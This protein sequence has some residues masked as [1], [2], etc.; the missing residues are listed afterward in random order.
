MNK[1]KL[2]MLISYQ[3]LKIYLLGNPRG[4]FYSLSASRA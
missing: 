4:H 3:A 1:G 2:E